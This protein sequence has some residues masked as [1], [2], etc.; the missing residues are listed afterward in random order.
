[1]GI[2]VVSGGASGI[3][4]ALS[5]A[6]GRRGASV[7]LA[8]VDEQVLTSVVEDFRS[9][10]INASG[11]PVDLRDL[12]AVG[13]L[14]DRASAEG[15]IETVCLNAGVSYSGPTIWDTP[16]SIWDFVFGVNCFALVNQL[17]AFVPILIRQQSPANIVITASMAGTLG[18]PSSAAYAASKAAAIS[19]AKSLRGELATSAP[20]LKVAL[21]NPGMVQSNLQRTSSGLQPSDVAVDQTFVEKSHSTLNGLGAPPDDV[22]GWVIDALDAGRFWVFPPSEDPFL[23]LLKAELAELTEAIEGGSS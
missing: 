15:T 8:D 4:L 19:L 22:A 7:I 20:F 23:A 11:F 16:R 5:R 1:M 3:G 9:S 13:R 18:L 12:D 21:L 2:V 14:A 10:G 17:A 6:Y